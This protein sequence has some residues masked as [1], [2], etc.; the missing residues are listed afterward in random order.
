MSCEGNRHRFFSLVEQRLPDVSA[1]TLERIYQA[2]KNGPETEDESVLDKKTR[3][4]FQDME[5][6]GIRPPTHSP[7][8][9]PK[10]ASCKGYAAVFDYLRSCKKGDDLIS[11]NQKHEEWKEYN[12]ATGFDFAA[13]RDFK[14]IAGF[15]GHACHKP[16]E[17]ARF[18]SGEEFS[19]QFYGTHRDPMIYPYDRAGVVGFMQNIDA[20]GMLSDGYDLTGFNQ[21]GLDRLGRNRYGLTA[22]DIQN[23]KLLNQL[24]QKT[25]EKN[26]LR[27]GRKTSK[28]IE[29]DVEGFSVT[30]GFRPTNGAEEGEDIDRLGF[31]RNGFRNGRTFTGYDENGLDVYGKPAPKRAGYDSFGYEKS[32]GL[33]APDEQGRRYN[34]I[35]WVYD[36]DSD[37]CYNPDDPTQ[38]MRHSG[39]FTY[40]SKARKV[41]LKRSYIPSHEE[42]VK[43]LKD[44]NIR[45][46][47]VKAGGAPLWHYAAIGDGYMTCVFQASPVYRY[48][49]SEERANRHPEASFA[50]IR[51]RCPKCG[52]F[53]GAAPHQC[54]HYGGKRILA[55]RNG[56]IIGL[57]PRNE[58]ADLAK[59]LPP[60]E[61]TTIQ[62]FIYDHVFKG[63]FS[64]PFFRLDLN[65][66]DI[67]S[68]DFSDSIYGYNDD[69]YP[70]RDLNKATE[71]ERFYTQIGVFRNTPENFSYFFEWDER[72]EAAV[73]LETPFTPLNEYNPDYHGGDLVGF[74]WKSGLTEDGYDLL[75]FHYLSGRHKYAEITREGLRLRARFAAQQNEVIESM[76]KRG[77]S[78]LRDLLQRTY[79]RIATSLAGAPR[80]VQ[81]S[82]EGGPRPGMFWTDMKGTI[83]AEMYPLSRSKY[84]TPANNLLAFKAGLYHEL[85]H[86]EDTPVEIFRRIISIASG[87]E[88]VPGIPKEQ[89]GLV[90]EIYNILEDGRME[91]EQ[92]RRRRGVAMILAADAQTNPRWDE[93]VGEDIPVTH[94][95]MG[96]MLYRSLPFFRVR[97][98]V[99][100]SAPPRV[101]KLFDEVLPYIDRAMISPEDTFACSIAISRKL[102][103][104]EK[105]QQLAQRMTQEKSQGGKWVEQDGNSSGLIISA[106]PRPG[107]GPKDEKLAPPPQDWKPEDALPGDKTNG[108][109]QKENQEGEAQQFGTSQEKQQG[110]G[111]RR[112]GTTQEEERGSNRKWDRAIQEEN[113]NESSGYSL[114][115]SKGSIISH[116]VDQ[117]FFSKFSDS[118]HVIESALS[119][120]LT[121]LRNSVRLAT[122]PFGK[123]MLKPSSTETEIILPADEHR[124]NELSVRHITAHTGSMRGET[125]NKIRRIRES[126]RREGLRLARRLAVLKQEVNRKVHFQTEGAPDRRRYKRAVTG[127]ENVYRR[128]RLVDVTSLAVGIQV[129]MSGSMSQEISSGHLAGV[130]ATIEEALRNLDAELFVT[131]FGSETAVVKTLGDEKISDESLAALTEVSLGGTIPDDALILSL[132]TFRETKSSNKLHFMLTDGD[133]DY[134]ES[135]NITRQM[136]QNGIVPFGL[137]LGEEMSS[138]IRQTFNTVFGEGNWVQ[139]RQ[140]SDMAD[141]VGERI[142]RIYRRI[143]ATR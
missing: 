26:I 35:G 136:R 22:S 83:Q 116:E 20:N 62:E 90:A 75:G 88:E 125:L 15:I 46:R 108:P 87:E 54:P 74:H 97:Q 123:Q 37:T 29:L 133:F 59:H 102:L 143:L 112:D 64:S 38:R 6:V 28:I 39:S 89:A 45:M 117:D 98:E 31:N 65:G 76:K 78:N 16:G 34:L 134:E 2:A 14:N 1:Q 12:L 81:I 128:E 66:V 42:L 107:K 91:R 86:E 41:V 51:L 124:Q 114:D 69:R 44:P 10:K 118:P 63:Y 121:D 4:L 23:E 113:P 18:G 56:V 8:G 104:D 79:S 52:Q 24:A 99:Y 58:T 84:N 132:H 138:H 142:E 101:R 126:A 50:G 60:S 9:L 11:E 5:E 40:S 130:T 17:D 7:D 55:L 30:D 57:F 21:Q 82:E 139:I 109:K 120:V 93:K 103:Q 3:L 25:V 53:T 49:T 129:D 119:D 95:V 73:V 19:K 127:S 140:L 47:E 67:Q 106:L 92:S 96:M 131:A 71:W 13:L 36:P 80:R 111:K 77:I 61:R 137:F 43:R 115:G 72:K 27:P 70:F 48:L 68:L 85:G 94:Q 33:T 141:V 110:D 135:A 105:F 122:E 32:T 100:D